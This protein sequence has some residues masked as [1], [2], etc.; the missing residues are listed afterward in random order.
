MRTM[1]YIVFSILLAISLETTI[2]LRSVGCFGSLPKGFQPGKSH[3]VT[4]SVL[5][6]VMGRNVDRY[7]RLYIPGEYNTNLSIPLVVDFHGWG[8][9]SSFQEKDSQFIKVSEEDSDPFFVAT[10]DGMGDNLE[11]GNWGSFNCSR[12]DGPLGPPCDLDRD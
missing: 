2:G 11:E 5:D 4:L 9:S 12:T 7:F 3:L 10:P 8:G 6:P 1:K